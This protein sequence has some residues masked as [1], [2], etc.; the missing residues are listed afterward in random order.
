MLVHLRIVSPPDRTEVVLATVSSEGAAA[1]VAVLRGASLEPEGDLILCDVAREGVND[2]V[3]AL[4]DLDIHRVGSIAIDHIDVSVSDAAAGAELRIPGHGSEAAVWEEVDAQVR[5]ESMLTASFLL[6]LVI[7]ALIAAVGLA[8]DSPVLIVGAMVVGP[9]FGPISGLSVGIFKARLARVRI[10]LTTLLVG[11][12]AGVL[13]VCGATMASDALGLVPGTFSPGKQPLTSFIVDPSA[14]SFGVAVL[15]GVAGTLSLTEAKAS[16]LVGV[17]ISVTTIPAIA[18]IG[19][20]AALGE[21]GD[22]TAAATQL[23]L[24]VTGLVFA[25]VITL[26]LQRKVWEQVLRPARQRR[27]AA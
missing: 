19:V 5:D 18:A 11:V 12:A 14:L 15:A 8:E 3:S 6:F 22:M 25:G 9:E 27:G 1:N 2:V 7:A 21:W 16:A 4:R 23:T 24:N 26:W 20:S 17:L 10:A 13:T